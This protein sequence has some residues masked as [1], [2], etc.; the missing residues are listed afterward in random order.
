MILPFQPIYHACN[1]LR[2]CWTVFAFPVVSKHHALLSDIS[3]F[4]ARMNGMPE[5]M[6]Y[7][8][9]ARPTFFCDGWI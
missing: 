5:C 6:L 8:A 1:K 9:G 3:L 4:P 2:V 7:S